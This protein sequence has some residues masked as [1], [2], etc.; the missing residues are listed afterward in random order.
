MASSPTRAIAQISANGSYEYSE[1]FYL[2]NPTPGSGNISLSGNGRMFS[3]GAFTLFGVD[4]CIAPSVVGHDGTSGNSSSVQP[5]RFYCG[6]LIGS[7]R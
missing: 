3:V 1:I 5:V 4:V 7:R 6:R 2:F